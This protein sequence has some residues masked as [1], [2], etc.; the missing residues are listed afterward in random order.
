MSLGGGV[1]WVLEV[2]VAMEVGCWRGGAGTGELGLPQA[3]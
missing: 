1:G 3:Y 2:A